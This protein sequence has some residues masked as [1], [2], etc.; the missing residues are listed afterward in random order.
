MKYLITGYL[1]ILS[2]FA[3]FAYNVI[4]EDNDKKNT[5]VKD[6]AVNCY[7]VGNGVVIITNIYDEIIKVWKPDTIDGIPNTYKCG[8]NK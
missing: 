2:M 7:E 5:S 3:I 4:D 8:K 1:I 6:S